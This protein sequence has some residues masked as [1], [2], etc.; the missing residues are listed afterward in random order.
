[1]SMFLYA[2]PSIGFSFLYYPMFLIFYSYLIFIPIIIPYFLLQCSGTPDTVITFNDDTR[3]A[4]SVQPEI[5]RECT[6]PFRLPRLST[7]SSLVSGK[8]RESC[9]SLTEDISSHSSTR[10]ALKENGN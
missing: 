5:S 3:G 10:K 6:S 1:M 4:D 9:T 8:D 7:R 2:K